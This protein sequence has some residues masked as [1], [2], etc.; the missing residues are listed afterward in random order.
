MMHIYRR[1]RRLAAFAT[2]IV[3]LSLVLVGVR[4]PDPGAVHAPKP[5]PRAVL[6]TQIKETHAVVKKAA[7]GVAL[8][9]PPLLQ[10]ALRYWP[11]R[12]RREGASPQHAP[13]FP[14]ASRAPPAALV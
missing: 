11:E 9:P 7:D 10:C 8:L 3:A 14:H 12:A 6:E 13:L 1:H 4:L 2:C 5:R